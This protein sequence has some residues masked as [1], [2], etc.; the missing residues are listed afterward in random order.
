MVWPQFD[1]DLYSRVATFK[2]HGLFSNITATVL[3]VSFQ[4]VTKD[5]GNQGTKDMCPHF[6][7]YALFIMS[8]LFR[9]V[10]KW[11]HFLR[12]CFLGQP[13]GWF[14]LL[15]SKTSTAAIGEKYFKFTIIIYNIFH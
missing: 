15:L 6:W 10:G 12:S 14:L 3:P 1:W 13:L 2:P 11:Q 4:V 5:F 8:F 7:V 9:T